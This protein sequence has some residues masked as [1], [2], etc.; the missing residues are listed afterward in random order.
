M[1]D[2]KLLSDA[3]CIGNIEYMR[4]TRAEGFSFSY[5]NGRSKSGFIYV[6]DGKIAHNFVSDEIE[7]TE[8]SRGD[9][10]FIPKG[11]GYTTHYKADVTSLTIVQF[12]LIS[13]ELPSALSKPVKLF[14]PDVSH[15]IRRITTY[16]DFTEIG[17][18]KA[19]YTMAMVYE[20]LWKSITSLRSPESK[21]LAQK[22]SPALSELTSNYKAQHLMN[23]YASL[24]FMSETAFRRAFREYSGISP[25]KY[26]NKL[27]IEE[28]NRLICSE[29]YSIKEAAEEVGFTNIS[30]FHRVYKSIFGHTP[31]GCR[32]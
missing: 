7:N 8:L 5:P 22:L 29:E 18:G 30:F 28:A 4:V 16:P 19:L 12:D 10:I 21:I 24:C 20:L 13:G 3:F 27:R 31:G 23:Y 25:V 2:R 17:D 15:L 11:H 26:R 6:E 32:Q 1:M 14:I 9:L